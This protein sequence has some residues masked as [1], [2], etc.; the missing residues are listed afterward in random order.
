MEVLQSFVLDGT[1]YEVK[2]H[3]Y[4]EEPYFRANDIADV[5][6]MTCIRKTLSSFDDDER[7]SVS[8]IHACSEHSETIYLTEI[9][10]YRLLMISRKPIARPFQKW[11][12]NVIKDIR[13]NGRYELQKYMEQVEIEK[14]QLTLALQAEA[15]KYKKEASQT[16]HKSLVDAY[17][18]KYIVYIGVV[19]HRDNKL[20]I[21][22]GSTKNMRD[23]A[24]GLVNDF[25]SFEL[26]KCIEIGLA[27]EEFERFILRHKDLQQF[28]YEDSMDNGK[29]SIETF[30]MSNQ[31]I[32]FLMNIALKNAYKFRMK[33][34]SEH[35][36]EIHR[37]MTDLER[38][39]LEQM[40]VELEKKRLEVLHQPSSTSPHVVDSAA[41]TSAVEQQVVPTFDPKLYFRP[42]NFTQARGTK[43]QRYT[44]DGKTLL[45]TYPSGIHVKRDAKF[46]CPPSSPCLKKAI[47]ANTVYKGFRWASLARDKP[48][49]TV[50]ELHETVK[51]KEVHYGEYIAAIDAHKTKIVKVYPDQKAAA[52]EYNTRLGNICSAIKRGNKSNGHHWN[53]WSQCSDEMKTQYLENNELPEKRAYRDS[54]PIEQIDVVTQKVLKTYNSVN[55][56]LKDFPFSRMSLYNA[57]HNGFPEKG[58]LWKFAM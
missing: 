27:Y 58:Y 33:A 55:A 49:D 10:L 51:G 46:D 26:I 16:L 45:E 22:V 6:G 23:R 24:Y 4:E 40:K 48:D 38:V 19:G 12:T 9:G 53:Y 17:S 41:S 28:V 52:E 13:K 47:E 21:K 57:I 14:E 39:K 43:I 1:S 54:K 29:N 42:R 11:V 31:D 18:N 32:Q 34:T 30:L 7:V 5:L 35:E 36:L 44:P 8:S 56:V 25:G 15:N 2:V 3:W 20:I 37:V 50:Q